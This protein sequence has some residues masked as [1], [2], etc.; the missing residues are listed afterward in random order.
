MTGSVLLGLL[1]ASPAFAG[2]LVVTMLDVGQGDGLLLQTPGGANILVDAGLARAQTNRQLLG[3]GVL[4]L[5]LV[6]ASHP[7]A[8]HIGAMGQVLTTLPPDRFWY[9]GMDHDTQAWAKVLAALDAS[10]VAR[11][12]VA[13][14]DRL[15]IDDVVLEVLWPGETLLSN[16]RSDL[17]ANSVVLR[18]EH[19][20]DCLLLTGDAEEVTEVQLLRRDLGPCQVLK[21]AHH[22]SRHSTSQAFLDA[23][24]PEIALISVGAD[25]RYDHPGDETM[26]RLLEADITIYRT[27]LT[28]PVQLSSSGSGWTVTDGLP[29]DAPLDPE[30]VVV[31]PA[32][33]PEPEPAHE[34]PEPEATAGDP[35]TGQSRQGWLRRLLERHRT[36]REARGGTAQ[37]HDGVR[38]SAPRLPL[39]TVGL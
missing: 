15:V 34:A 21:V 3:F 19:G 14:G 13:I 36:R 18:V 4:H 7:H 33:K 6:V 29:W 30:D 32:P 26:A 16:T 28:G 1:L 8:D 24:Q 38:D 9:G 23:V 22:G 31:A 20:S 27:D 37:Y 11:E 39:A 10:G 2:E 35:D 17:N 5:D 12:A 25:N